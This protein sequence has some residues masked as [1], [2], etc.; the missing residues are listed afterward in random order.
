[1]R[2]YQI[3]VVFVLV[4]SISISANAQTK[5]NGKT[6]PCADNKQ[7]EALQQHIDSLV[8]SKVSENQP[9]VAIGVLWDDKVWMKKAYGLMNI[10]QNSSIDENTVFN[11]A[12]VSK[13]FTA[14]AILKLEEEGKLNLDDNIRDYLPKL[15]AYENVITIR[16]LIQHTSGIASTD[17]L[18][19]FAGVS[20][21]KQWSQQNEIDLIMSYP[22]L[23]FT[24]NSQHVYSNAGYSI[25]TQIVEIV[26]EMKFSEFLKKKVF[27]P[28][29]MSS[30]F[31]YDDPKID[32]ST[33]STG[34]K[35][36]KDQFIPFGN[37]KDYTYGAGNIHTSLND[38]LRWGQNI[39]SS[40]IGQDNYINKI[41]NTYNT[42]NNGDTLTYTYGF[43]VKNYKGI[44]MVEHSGGDLGF[45]SQFMIFP[46]EKLLLVLLFNTESINTRRLAYQ[47]TD[48]IFAGKIIEEAPK[49]R[50]EI[51]VEKEKL[52]LL[53]GDYQ[54]PDG[55]QFGFD[56]KQDTLWLVL[57]GEDRY[58]LYAESPN[59]FFLKA[60]K[61]QCTFIKG[62]DGS[63]NELIW[64]QGGK[65]YKADKTVKRKSL[66]KEELAC[67]VGKYYHNSL[68]VEYPI[69]LQ[70]DI[71]TITPPST[72]KTY[73]DFD[74][75]KLSHLKGDK[76]STDNFGLLEFTRNDANQI[77]GFVLL[78]VGRV[79]NIRF[80]KN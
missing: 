64:H 66:T 47:I 9:G 13:Q 72:F 51:T 36:G 22:Q 11:I 53:E 28:L 16:N 54:M 41:S 43:Y 78:D 1:M 48:L 15:P 35:K 79:Q 12:S 17:V 29:A 21:E 31:V 67:Y 34:Y 52:Q 71:L 44:K 69:A 26:S 8:A 5:K 40:S 50:V 42:L 30:S 63:V 80:S 59:H 23:N 14:F 46:E 3:L 37:G 4:L 65:D 60:F 24:P 19:L 68:K 20:F 6:S 49:Q 27:D 61:A 10:D 38:M 57:P 56:L 74:S 76:F 39:F 55:M 18:R 58:P 25:L 7:K 77:N 33:C 32:L 45:R 62:S 73:L 2:T 70:D 75:V